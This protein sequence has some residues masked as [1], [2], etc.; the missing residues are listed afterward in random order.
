MLNEI[1]NYWTY[2]YINACAEQLALGTTT[3]GTYTFGGCSIEQSL[4][5]G[6]V[7]FSLSFAIKNLP[8]LSISRIEDF[9]QATCTQNAI[10][11][12]NVTT[13]YQRRTTR[14]MHKIADDTY[15][16]SRPRAKG[17]KKE[18]YARRNYSQGNSDMGGLPGSNEGFCSLQVIKFTDLEKFVDKLNAY[19]EGEGDPV[20]PDA[21]DEET[22]LRYRSFS[23]TAH[24]K[25]ILGKRILPLLAGEN[26]GY[27]VQQVQQPKL[28]VTVTGSATAQGEPPPVGW[29][30][31]ASFVHE[32]LDTDSDNVI[33]LAHDVNP[34]APT[35]DGIYG[36]T[37]H[38]V[39]E[40]INTDALKQQLRLPRTPMYGG[41]AISYG[42]KKHVRWLPEKGTY[43]KK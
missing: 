27:I 4:F 24:Y 11:N 12:F 37:W 34:S 3:T 1:I 29:D 20:Q 21:D 36:V 5:D 25:R 26:N 10:H 18:G 42:A 13:R 8:D 17:K 35:V 6:K 9:Q 39:Y 31:P 22:K 7:N 19:G 43:T 40:I 16:A 30:D 2:N 38:Y 32:E 33:L 28:R 15:Q 14:K 41:E 23:Q